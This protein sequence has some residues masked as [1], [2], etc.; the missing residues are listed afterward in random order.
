MNNNEYREKIMQLLEKNRGGRH[1]ILYLYNYQEVTGL[2]KLSPFL[3]QF[4]LRFSLIRSI[5]LHPILKGR[6]SVF[7]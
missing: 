4:P 2:R 7:P 6:V 3:L 1:V 5:H